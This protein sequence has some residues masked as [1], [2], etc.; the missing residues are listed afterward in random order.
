MG[1]ETM[2]FCSR[3]EITRRDDHRRRDASQTTSLG[4]AVRWSVGL[5][6][7]ILSVLVEG[8]ALPPLKSV[9]PVESVAPGATPTVPA[10]RVPATTSPIPTTEI[11]NPATETP[12]TE[13]PRTG[14]PTTRTP[15]PSSTP[16]PRVDV[17]ID[18]GHG[19][20][21]TGE[22]GT[23]L[24]GSEV[25]EKT[26][27][28]AVALR[29]AAVLRSAGRTVVLYRT[30]DSLPGMVSAD[31]TA[32]GT[33]LTPDGLLANLQRRIDAANASHARVL[34]SI[35]FNAFSDPSVGGSETYYDGARP[36]ASQSEHFANLIQSSWIA[37]LRAN[38][39]D[40]PDR[41]V[42]DDQDLQA[43]SFGTLGVSYNHLVL[44]GPPVPNRLQA[45]NMPGAVIEPLF[46]SD[47]TEATAIGQPAMQDLLAHA[48]A[49]G[50]E[51][52]LNGH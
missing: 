26:Y 48:L 18:P 17:F 38:A 40:T 10:D 37:A 45:S 52:F 16:R 3:L 32:D 39:Y 51:E 21:D 47:P 50:V 35:H 30:D 31:Y 7:I 6:L 19:G 25:L 13:T 11:G 1:V 8:C 36:F 12:R 27:T 44:L 41:G 5:A 28:L 49:K 4:R 46:L 20:V 33:A 23:T 9:R 34:L 14:T 15:V 2:S 22:I 43:D 29:T 42:G 24:D